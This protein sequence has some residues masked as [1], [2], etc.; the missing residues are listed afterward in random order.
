[1]T[2]AIVGAERQRTKWFKKMLK[3]EKGFGVF[4]LPAPSTHLRYDQSFARSAPTN[5]SI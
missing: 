3:T 4:T 5:N 1:M 2:W